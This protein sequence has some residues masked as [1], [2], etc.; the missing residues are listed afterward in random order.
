MSRRAASFALLAA[1]ARGASVWPLPASIS[2]DGRVIALSDS[3]T[4]TTT[5]PTP[6]LAAAF[7]R[8]AAILALRAPPL[9][10]TN[11][12]PA[13]SA[14]PLAAL[15]VAL[16]STDEALDVG[17]SE[18]YNLTVDA[19]A[20]TLAADTVFGALR[21]LETFAQ[22]VEARGA[23]GA[24]RVVAAAAVAD[25]PRFAHRGALVD[26]ARHFIPLRVLFDFIDAMAANKMNV[27]HWHLTDDQSFP[28]VSAALPALAAEGAFGKLASHTY[29]PADVAAV[30]AYARARGVR[31][32]SEFDTPGHTMSWGAGAPGLT[33]TC[34]APNGSVTGT[35]P[36]DPTRE[37]NFAIIGA[38]I[39][40]AA[41]VFP[42]AYM[43]IGGDEVDYTCWKSNPGVVAWMAAHGM[44]GNFSALESYFVQR[45]IGLVAAAG[46][47][48]VGWQE[49]Y[50]NRLA[51][52]AGT[53]VDV[54]KYHSFPCQAPPLPP[55]P[56]WQ[57][58]IANVTAAGFFAILS[59]PWYLNVIS[60]GVD[61][62]P[63][64]AADPTDF[65]GTAEQK[66]RV[67]GGELS[68]WGEWADSTN[69]ISRTWPRGSA[70]AERLWSPAST[71]DVG[72]ATRRIAELRCRLV[73]RGLAAGPL[74]PGYCPGE[75]DAR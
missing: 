23:G 42:D 45:V 33:T 19:H 51:L 29:A 17:T 2:L 56:T 10:P 43:H 11:A 21:G 12:T 6:L 61:W 14:P 71:T 73:A 39:A 32:V 38:L 40:E 25:S 24:A 54:W 58:E 44:A 70:V 36:V 52:P 8:Y 74:G 59:S 64:Y 63:Y 15:A 22:L 69:L 67:L 9:T 3:F 65:E 27:F 48:A 28:Y 50:D 66:A 68:M 75:F 57:S 72:D 30:I 46:K 62:P 60:Y 35:G 18:A 1:C 31:V 47:R 55:K 7:D 41:S 16:R 37:E 13:P 20:A 49:L 5:T 34:F 26:T 4:F 53:I